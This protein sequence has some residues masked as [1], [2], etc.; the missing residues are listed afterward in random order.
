MNKNRLFKLLKA[1][2]QKVFDTVEDFMH[3]HGYT[4]FTM[5]GGFL[6]GVPEK[7]NNTMLVAH[8]DTVKPAKTKVKLIEDKGMLYNKHGVLGADDRAGVEAMLSIV[9]NLEAQDPMPFLLLTA[10]E[11][12]GGLGAKAF[13]ESDILSTYQSEIYLMI[14]LDRR[15]VNEFVCYS[16]MDDEVYSI[17][18]TLGYDES[19]GSYSDVVDITD[20]YDIAHVNIGVGYFDQH[21]KFER[22]SYMGL[23]FAISNVPNIMD[24]VDRPLGTVEPVFSNKH[25]TFG[26]NKYGGGGSHYASGNYGYGLLPEDEQPYMYKDTPNGMQPIGNDKPACPYCGEVYDIEAEDATLFLCYHCFCM[27]DKNRQIYIDGQIR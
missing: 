21:T 6:F 26:M 8:A 20:A 11:E 27:Y 15:G 9:E 23:N 14:E 24:M 16:P 13:V 5:D 19:M 22:L 7:S 25:N 4:V 2:D 17:M 1:D 10:D 12:V 3:N 18:D